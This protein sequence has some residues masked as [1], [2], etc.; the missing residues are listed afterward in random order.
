MWILQKKPNSNKT[1]K[2]EELQFNLSLY[3]E[4][5]L[6]VEESSILDQHLL[7][8]PVCR[9]K[10]A[11]FQ[12]LRDGFRAIPR[13]AI[14]ADLLYALRSSLA[15]ELNVSQTQSW[16]NLSEEWR[17]WLT[18]RV[19]PV[20]VG[21]V[22]SL[23]IAIAFLFSLSSLK[24]STDKVIEKARINSN[25]TV[26]FTNPRP[27]SDSDDLIITNEELAALR[28]PV[29]SES[30]SLNTK[31][32][33]LSLTNSLMRGKMKNDEITFVADV[34]GDGL[35]QI[36]EV[37]E[38]PRSRQSMEDLSTALENDPAFVTG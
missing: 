9:I 13:P 11:E 26:I 33:L 18:L 28:T 29:S 6:D 16:F 25:R 27:V 2:C 34:F 19:M 21:T 5:E 8:C 10:L 1:M 38:A 14:P 31:G 32:A 37:V 22:V 36:A 23:S 24:V 4:G 3:A 12:N 15:A 20:G 30:P 7:H 35:A 17:D